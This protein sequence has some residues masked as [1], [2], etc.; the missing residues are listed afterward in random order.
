M[1]L[2]NILENAV[3]FIFSE[4]LAILFS[5]TVTFMKFPVLPNKFHVGLGCFQLEADKQ[6]P[7]PT[8]Y[9]SV[10]NF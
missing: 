8:P 5:L 10:N 6:F 9:V 1:V 2:R 3:P 4:F 7:H